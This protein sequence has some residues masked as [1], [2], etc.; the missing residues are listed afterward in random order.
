MSDSGSCWIFAIAV[1]RIITTLTSTKIARSIDVSLLTLK[2]SGGDRTDYVVSLVLSV[3]SPLHDW[4][5]GDRFYLVVPI[6]LKKR[7]TRHP[8]LGKIVRPTDPNRLGD[9]IIGIAE[10]DARSWECFS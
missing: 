8:N 9:N 7:S 1:S 2:F 10:D 3:R 5:T 4:L 6:C